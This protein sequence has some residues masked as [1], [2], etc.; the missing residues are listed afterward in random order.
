VVP[1]A[2]IP[3]NLDTV[4]CVVDAAA[5]KQLASG[6]RFLRR[7]NETACVNPVLYPVEV[8]RCPGLC[9]PGWGVSSGC[10]NVTRSRR[11]GL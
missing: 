3:Q 9:V 7:R 2:Y 10:E 1:V 8:H 4:V 6:D 5:V 11:T